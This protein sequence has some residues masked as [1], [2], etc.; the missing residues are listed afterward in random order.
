M[1]DETF[2]TSTQNAT[3]EELV[4]INSIKNDLK[5]VDIEQEMVIVYQHTYTLQELEL[6]INFYKTPEGQSILKKNQH[7]SEKLKDI[8]IKHI[9]QLMKKY[10]AT[11]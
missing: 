6:L 8:Q 5:A 4:T 9:Q 10:D 11:T 3:T 2:E 7:L 1:I